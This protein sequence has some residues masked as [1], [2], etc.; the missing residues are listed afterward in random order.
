MEGKLGKETVIKSSYRTVMHNWQRCPSPPPP[1]S[2]ED[3]PILSP[4]F[5]YCVHPTPHPFPAASNPNPIHVLYVMKREKHQRNTSLYL[6]LKQ[7]SLTAL[8]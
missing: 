6:N 1:P 2:H 8:Y 4:P 3:P 7:K 5:S